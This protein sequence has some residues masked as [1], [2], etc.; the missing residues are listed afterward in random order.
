[1]ASKR[2]ECSCGASK[3]VPVSETE[4]GDSVV[5]GD[6]DGWDR[7]VG[8]GGWMCPECIHLLFIT[9]LMTLLDRIEIEQDWTL[10]S[11]RFDLA[12]SVGYQVS[13]G[14]PITGSIQ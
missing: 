11:Q 14:E 2:L 3:D 6:L 13:L 12:E 10:S 8:E 7:P 9:K 4:Y 5:M 1:M